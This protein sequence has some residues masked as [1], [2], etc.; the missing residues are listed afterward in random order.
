MT[1]GPMRS[2]IGHKERKL[3]KVY[4]LIAVAPD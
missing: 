3:K 4:V 2:Y 1:N